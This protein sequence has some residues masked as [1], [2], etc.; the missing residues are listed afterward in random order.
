MS[1]GDQFMSLCSSKLV[2]LGFG[3]RPKI[4]YRLSFGLSEAKK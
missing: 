4:D 2:N 3:L 1:A